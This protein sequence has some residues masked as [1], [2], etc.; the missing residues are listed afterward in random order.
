MPPRIDVTLHV[1]GA[2][3]AKM[4][5]VIRESQERGLDRAADEVSRIMKDGYAEHDQ[6]GVLKN[7]VQVTTPAELERFVAP[8]VNY[9]PYFEKGTGPAAGEARYYP[10]P[11]KL[12]DFLRAH[13]R[14]RGFSW[15][16]PGSAKRGMQNL[17]LWLRSRAMARSIY[18]KGTQPHPVSEQTRDK[19]ESRV[20]AIMRESLA[21]GMQ[22]AKA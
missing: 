14:A 8:T 18:M 20:F 4:P 16:R 9:G 11:D 13:P 6:S 1:S 15:A 12:L 3:L 10:N 7:S 17:E 19:A 5:E 2:D 21:Q 22:G